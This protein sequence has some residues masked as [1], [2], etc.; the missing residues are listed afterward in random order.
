[1]EYPMATNSRLSRDRNLILKTLWA[2]PIAAVTGRAIPERLRAG[3]EYIDLQRL[4]A[5]VQR[6][7]HVMAPTGGE[8]PRKAVQT[9]TWTIIVAQ[10][11]ASA[12]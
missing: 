9:G 5:G 12:A 11:G 2:D 7:Q 1:M 6:A 4:Q 10:L 8:L 3:E